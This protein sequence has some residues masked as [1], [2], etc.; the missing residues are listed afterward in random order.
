MLAHVFPPFVISA[1]TAA[2]LCGSLTVHFL[3]LLPFAIIKLVVPHPRVR[4]AMTRVMLAVGR[5]FPRSNAV[6]L[7]LMFPV[8]WQIRID[9][10]LHPQKNYLLISNHQTW[11]D[12]VLLFHVFRGRV[13]WLRYFVK[14]E[15]LYVPVIGLAC[16]AFDFPFMKRYTREQI[17]ANP[18]LA[19][20]DLEATRRACE[21]FRETPV[22]IVNFL[23]GT[24]FTPAKRARKN[25][26][27]RYL[28]P[29]KSGGL[30]YAIGAMGRE[31]EGLVDVTIAYRPAT[32]KLVWSFAGGE[33][34]DIIIEVTLRPI[35]EHL[36]DGDYQGDPEFRR[37]FQSWVAELWRAKDERLAAL[38]AEH[39]AAIKQAAQNNRASSR[40][41]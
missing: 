29:P 15:L 22:T 28:L 5:Q 12:I 6:L 20:E 1:L 7:R 4:V 30:A 17:A 35:P 13:P 36:L 19:R 38:H 18:N 41:T 32:R 25:S 14:R 9:G 37:A 10:E 34:R 24:R 2:L 16:W 31:V 3:M 23:E 27:Y 8:R 11:A 26:P 33:Q 39:A 21:R 40:I